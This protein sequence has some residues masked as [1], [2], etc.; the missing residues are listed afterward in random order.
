[1]AGDFFRSVPKGG[2]QLAFRTSGFPRSGTSDFRRSNQ[3]LLCTNDPGGRWQLIKI[4]ASF[5]LH[6]RSVFKA[7]VLIMP[8]KIYSSST[9]TLYDYQVSKG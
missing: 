3:T 4:L 6:L 8:T 2:R 5:F 1:M 9:P 7:F